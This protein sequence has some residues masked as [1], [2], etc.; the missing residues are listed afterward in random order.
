MKTYLS[1][2]NEREKW[3]LIGS[4]L[5]LILYCY[6]LFLYTPLSHQ[7]TQKSTQLV[8]K[9][10]TLDWMKKIRQQ[11]HKSKTKETVD[12]SQ[13]LTIL[14]TQLKEDSTLK[15][16]YQLQQTGSGDIQLTF[17][18][19][20]FNLFIAWLEKINERYAVS[21]K[22]FNAERTPTPGVVHVMVLLSAAT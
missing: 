10:A 22:Q 9:I 20:A 14:A 19:V 4:V 12:N 6:Y 13:L 11:N 8:E 21:L 5:C 16:P 2:L 15:F 3:M 7:V 18:A 17:D 1:T